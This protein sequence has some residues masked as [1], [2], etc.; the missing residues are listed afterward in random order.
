[1]SIEIRKFITGISIP[2]QF[3][4][5]FLIFKYRSFVRLGEWNTGTD[6]DCQGKICANAPVDIL[7]EKTFYRSY[8]NEYQWHDNIGLIKLSEYVIFNEWISPICLPIA[9]HFYSKPNV[10]TENQIYIITGFNENTCLLPDNIIIRIFPF[11]IRLF[12][13]DFQLI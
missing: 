11:L 9:K 7:V 5:I 10:Y 6:I 4:L 2:I 13:F 12:S 3:V 8:N 1:M